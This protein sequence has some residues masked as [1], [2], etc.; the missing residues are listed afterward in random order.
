MHCGIYIIIS[1]GSIASRNNLRFWVKFN[2][3]TQILGV[4]RCLLNNAGVMLTQFCHH[5]IV[6]SIMLITAGQ[7]IRPIKDRE[8]KF[9]RQKLF[10]KYIVSCIHL[11]EICKS[12][13]FNQTYAFYLSLIEDLACSDLMNFYLFVIFFS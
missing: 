13:F 1:I 10:S 6:F 5:E 12:C 9:S 7:W 2:L 11:K 8:M 3:A 4:E